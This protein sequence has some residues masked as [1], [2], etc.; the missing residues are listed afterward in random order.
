MFGY[1]V[2]DKIVMQKKRYIYVCAWEASQYAASWKVE[3]QNE[4]KDESVLQNF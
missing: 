4:K 3:G 2:N 1:S